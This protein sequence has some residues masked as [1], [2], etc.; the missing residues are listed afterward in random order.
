MLKNNN[1]TK[2]NDLDRLERLLALSANID[3][4]AAELGLVAPNP[5]LTWA[6]GAG[7]AWE[8]AVATAIV[9]N[10]PMGTGGSRTAPTNIFGNRTN[11]SAPAYIWFGRRSE[12]IISQNES[13]I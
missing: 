2:D 6:Q 7:A 9:A 11:Q 8:A 13:Y 5:L 12:M 10:D 1:F 4:Y 3:T